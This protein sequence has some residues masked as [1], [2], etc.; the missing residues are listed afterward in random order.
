MSRTAVLAAVMVAALLVPGVA[1]AGPRPPLPPSAPRVLLAFL[2][3]RPTGPQSEI[4]LSRFAHR[5]QLGGLGMMSS[6]AGRYDATQTLID[7]SQGT[8]TSFNVYDPKETPEI[9]LVP[10][11]GEGFVEGWLDIQARA[12]SPPEVVVPGNLGSAIPGGAGYVGIIDQPNPT[13]L[14]A[15]NTDGYVRGLSLDKP[16]SIV[17]RTQAMLNR[18][19]FVVVGLPAGVA[20]GQ[21][22]D[23]LLAQRP[24][25][26][27]ILVVR[28]PPD[29]SSALLLP[30]AS[31]GLGSGN[32]SSSTTRDSGLVT[33]ID[34]L[35][36][37]MQWLRLPL[38]KNVKGEPMDVSGKRD[39][40][41][42]LSFAKRS[43]VVGSRRVQTLQGALLAWL[44]VMLAL[45]VVAGPRGIRRGMRVGGLG[46]LWIPV[47]MLI[48][49]SFEPTRALELVIVCG[50]SLL[51]GV[52]TDLVLRWPRGV[53]LPALGVTAAY[54]VDLARGSDLIARS[55]LGPNPRLGSRFYG[56][57]NELEAIIPVIVLAGLA[58]VP[59]LE[60]RSRRSAV[61]FGLAGLA[62][63][64]VVGSGR[65]G[66]DVGGVITVGVGFAVATA[67][68]LP[69]RA[70]WR[71]VVAV[72]L[73]PVAALALLA[74]IDIVTHGNSHFTRSVLGA[75]SVTELW[76]TV[77][78]RYELAY[79]QLLRGLMP[80]LTM[81][82]LLAGLYGVRHRETLLAPVRGIPSWTAALTGG[83]CGSIAG[84]LSNDS[85]PVIIVYAVSALWF[86]VAYLR[87]DP[88]LVPTEPPVPPSSGTGA[89]ADPAPPQERPAE[90]P[91]QPAARG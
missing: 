23:G 34:I 83:L 75:G 26:E 71:R 67:M 66:A 54:A 43:G 33:T 6:T 41:A 1:A 39:A 60:R 58:A 69:G 91:L 53:I 29:K 3:G 5:P 61:A 18:R 80:V 42:I 13:A 82:A 79:Q 25:D 81:L 4:I 19:R 87:G 28:T 88:R 31:S 2:P 76:D 70:S 57:G 27:L 38:P 72:L 84:A 10:Y 17:A 77:K 37:V 49:A 15:A 40:A 22:L 44:G 14:V 85:G 51:L 36:T 68:M 46:A 12:A 89:A 62:L 52:L 56:L 8:R 64:I 78:R 47:A 16:E 20:G 32:L 48:P 7:I 9:A 11:R 55:L 50:V 86:V 59:A 65:L 35:P 21:A 63:G 45:G 90:A 74:L 30:I 24:R 73:V